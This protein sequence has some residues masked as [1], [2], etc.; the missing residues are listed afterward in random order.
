[1]RVIGEEDLI[2]TTFKVFEECSYLYL[3]ED[4]HWGGDLDMI[5]EEIDRFKEPRVL[6]AGCGPAW[7]L[8]NIPYLCPSVSD[9]V[10]LDYSPKMLDLAKR[11]VALND[12]DKRIKLVKGNILSMPFD[13]EK[14]EI[15]LCLS[16]TFG[17][18]P[19]KTFEKSVKIRKKTV[20]EFRRVLKPG[21][22][23][24]LS[25]YNVER[26][27]KEDKYGR[28]FSLDPVLSKLETNDFIVRFTDPRKNTS[29]S[30]IPY[31]SHWFREQEIKLLI[32]NPWFRIKELEKRMKR[33]V[34]VAEKL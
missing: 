1:M 3:Q 14:F 17:N 19:E 21:G 28:V 31:Y 15:V 33:I 26:I 4:K 13:N 11:F 12:L 6:D 24:I 9:L 18:L 22:S 20:R 10:G 27:K 7:H 8:I 16:N 5:R 32:N 29:N 25:V 23:L 34:I 2:A 30:G